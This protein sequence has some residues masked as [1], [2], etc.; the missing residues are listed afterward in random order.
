MRELEYR[1]YSI[2]FSCNANW[3]AHIRKPGGFLILKDSFITAS[4]EEGEGVLL[5]RARARI[6]QEEGGSPVG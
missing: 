2:R 6:D 4:L 1:G 3:T 5:E